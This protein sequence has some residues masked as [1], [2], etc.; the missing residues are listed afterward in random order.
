MGGWPG[1]PPFRLHRVADL[2]ADGAN[3]TEIRT[4]T[5]VGTHIDAPLH[6]V[7]GGGDVAGLAI[8]RLC[9]EAVVV[10][11]SHGRDVV[12]ED[13]RS[14][15]I[16]AGDRVLLRMSAER[17]SADS[18]LRPAGPSEQQGRE[19]S[20]HPQVAAPGRKNH[21]DT[22]FLAR[23]GK[24]SAVTPEAAQWLV[25]AGVVLLGIDQAS[26]DPVERPDLPAHR[27]LLGAGVPILENLDLRQAAPG[28]YE[29]IVLPLPIRGGEAAPARAILLPSV[30]C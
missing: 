13:L 17:E 8:D 12:V 20:V 4:S 1:D 11:L 21:P 30:A 26:P 19:H 3:V 18:T 24:V 29:L 15:P 14:A 22:F 10:D 6:C 23:E 25:D 7:A 16:R 27:I 2:E 5:H 28:R 9:G